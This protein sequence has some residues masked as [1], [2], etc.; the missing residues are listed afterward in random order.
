[1]T[2]F[3][4]GQSP[5]PV[6][7]PILAMARMLSGASSPHVGYAQRVVDRYLAGNVA[8]ALATA[9]SETVDL[10]TVQ[11]EPDAAERPQP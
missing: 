6:K 9:R 2:A 8:Q 4:P 11:P 10:T 7:T 3:N 1:M 5:P